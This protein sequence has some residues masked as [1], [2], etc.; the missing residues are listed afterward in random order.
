MTLLIPQRTRTVF[1]TGIPAEAGLGSLFPGI[2]PS[3]CLRQLCLPSSRL[4]SW[5]PF[6]PL[7]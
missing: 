4:L 7:L 2:P 3:F 1:R 6:C 5:S